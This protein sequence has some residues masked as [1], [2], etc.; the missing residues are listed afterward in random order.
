M[1][2]EQHV[3]NKVIEDWKECKLDVSLRDYITIVMLHRI[4]LSLNSIDCELEEWRNGME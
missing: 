1:N 3:V 4:D 2:H